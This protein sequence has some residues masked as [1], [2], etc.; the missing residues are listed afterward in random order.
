MF[1]WGGGV[2]VWLGWGEKREGEFGGL[3]NA[4]VVVLLCLG[5]VA[6]AHQALLE[7][8]QVGK[9]NLNLSFC[10]LMLLLLQ[11]FT[12]IL[13]T[14]GTKYN[15]TNKEEFVENFGGHPGNQL[16]C[17]QHIYIHTCDQIPNHAL[18][19]WLLGCLQILRLE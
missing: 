10:S 15:Q 12:R 9:R 16:N 14:I 1:F 3:L 13:E 11:S 8:L 6:R 18:L 2:W 4:Q 19:S 17:I 5:V 7:F